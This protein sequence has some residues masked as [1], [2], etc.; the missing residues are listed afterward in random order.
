MQRIILALCVFTTLMLSGCVSDY[1][2]RQNQKMTAERENQL[3]IQEDI[4][5]LSGRLETVEL[6]IERLALD[7]DQAGS[8]QQSMMQQRLASIEEGLRELSS[9]VQQ[10]DQARIK[11][12]EEVVNIISEKITTLLKTTQAAQASSGSRASRSGYGYEHTVQSGESLSAI[13]SAYGVSMQA[14]VKENNLKNPDRLRVGQT[15]F[16]PE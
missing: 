15:L 2:G 13:A 6:E 16:I 9:R 7:M 11:D 10:I 8:R 3:L 12:R 5:Q 4:R 14:I 1:Y